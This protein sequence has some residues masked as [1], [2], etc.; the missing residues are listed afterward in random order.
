MFVSCSA[1]EFVELAGGSY[2]GLC[3]GAYYG[4]SRVVFEP[5]TPLE[6]IGDREL[7]FFPGIARGAAYPGG[8]VGGWGGGC[9]GVVGW[10]G[11]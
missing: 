11:K 9:V 7:A 4:S 1:A 8:L 3:A 5:G 6:V 2:L 10:V